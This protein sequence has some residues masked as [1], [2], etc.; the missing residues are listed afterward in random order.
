MSEELKQF[1]NGMARYP[2]KFGYDDDG[3]LIELNKEGTV[4]KT[5]A[6]P[7][8][9]PPTLEEFDETINKSVNETIARSIN[10]SITTLAVL[11][12]IF[13]FGGETI[14]DFVLALIV[15]VSLGAYSS[16]FVASPLLVTIKKFTTK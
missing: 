4:I 5:I 14:K 2:E 1:Y 10:T 13:L 8:Y 15:G 3:N 7:N 11:I 9:R 16:I 12:V 6:I